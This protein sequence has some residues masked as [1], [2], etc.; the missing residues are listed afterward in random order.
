M[1]PLLTSK[2][3]IAVIIYL[4]TDR[5]MSEAEERPWDQLS[6]ENSR[7]YRRFQA[8][9]KLGTSRSVLAIYNAERERKG[10][11]KRTLTFPESW[12]KAQTKYCWAERVNAWDKARQEEQ[13]RAWAM[14][15]EQEMRDELAYAE[16]LRQKSLAMLTLPKVSV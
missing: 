7:W 5:S 12:G 11:R 1:N 4:S 10:E 9:L 8:W 15:R 6:G 3:W 16:L 13:D 2:Q 14:L